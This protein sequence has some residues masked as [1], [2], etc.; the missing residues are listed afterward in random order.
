MPGGGKREMGRKNTCVDAE[1]R[2][3]GLDRGDGED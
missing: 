2:G 3:G 1:A